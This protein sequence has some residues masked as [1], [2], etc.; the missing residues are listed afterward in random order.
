MCVYKILRGVAICCAAHEKFGARKFFRATSYVAYFRKAVFVNYK[1][2]VQTL[3]NA[4]RFGMTPS[5]E[6]ITCMCKAMQNP[7]Q[8][9]ECVQ[10]AGTNGKSSTAR[11]IAFLLAAQG[12]RVGLYTSPGLTSYN[13]RI[14]V[15]SPGCKSAHTENAYI[16]SAHLESTHTKSTHIEGAHTI[17]D[18]DFARAIEAAVNA[19]K[20]ANVVPTEFELLTA[21]ALWY[22]AQEQLDVVV[23]E[24]GLGGRWDATSVV[25]PKLAVITGVGLDHTK[26]LGDTLEQIA[27]EKAA[28]I[29]SGCTAVFAPNLQERAVFETQAASVGAPIINAADKPYLACA[30]TILKSKEINF[31]QYQRNNIA[32]ALCAACAACAACALYKKEINQTQSSIAAKENASS[33]ATAHNSDTEKSDAEKPG[34]E[35]NTPEIIQA[36]KNC[37]IPGR[38]EYLSKDPLLIIDAAHNPQSAAVL[39]KEV[40]Q[41]F[42]KEKM[43][44][45]LLGILADKD[46]RGIV[47][48]LTRVFANIVVTQSSSPRALSTEELAKIVQE[49][50]GNS[51]KQIS[52]IEQAIQELHKSK[53]LDLIATGSITVAGQVKRLFKLHS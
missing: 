14:C 30:D 52:N 25:N 35:I 8:K 2:A 3:Q 40:E 42:S 22:F 34:T 53:Q 24:C 33:A 28:I 44:T 6:P 49:E 43:P 9:Y 5:L 19:G 39:A 31:P 15:V 41:R 51:P 47:R 32:T 37:N 17:S 50:T 23:L 4:L 7:Q 27:G 1:E 26:I 29:K 16:K 20:K 46:A 36:L 38:F 11:M 21:A 10:V 48:E 13:D 18:D 12:K 45:L